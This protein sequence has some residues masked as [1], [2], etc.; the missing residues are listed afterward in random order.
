VGAGSQQ[1]KENLPKRDEIFLYA[2]KKIHGIFKTDVYRLLA[3]H[4]APGIF[5]RNLTNRQSRTRNSLTAEIFYCFST[6]V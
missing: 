6:S 2:E 4:E 5:E 3:V 1:Q